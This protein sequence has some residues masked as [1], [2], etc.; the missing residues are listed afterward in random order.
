M[1]DDHGY[2]NVPT[3]WVEP[4]YALRTFVIR[5]GQLDW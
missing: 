4:V 5:D 1:T 2:G 3:E